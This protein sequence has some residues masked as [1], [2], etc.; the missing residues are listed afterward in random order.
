MRITKD[1]KPLRQEN[2]TAIIGNIYVFTEGSHRGEVFAAGPNELYIFYSGLINR[3]S[4]EDD[5]VENQHFEPYNGEIRL[6]NK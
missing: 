4:W 5:G 6:E 1:P 2:Y 3:H